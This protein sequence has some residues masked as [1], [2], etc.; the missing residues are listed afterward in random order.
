MDK[1]YFKLNVPVGTKIISSRGDYVVEEI[2][3][4]AFILF[5]T[6]SQWLSLLPEAADILAKKSEFELKKMLLIKERQGKESDVKIL[7]QALKIQENKKEAKA[8]KDER[9][10][11]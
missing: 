8:K 1:K 6:G 11:A 2:P 3:D 9:P 10:K 4:N 7:Q 5:S